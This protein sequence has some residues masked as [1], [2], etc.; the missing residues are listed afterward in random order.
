MAKDHLV[1]ASI[2]FL[3]GNSSFLP[4]MGSYL[5]RDTRGVTQTYRKTAQAQSR[6]W[7]VP[8]SCREPCR[9]HP[10]YELARHFWDPST[11]ALAICAHHQR[12]FKQKSG[13]GF[14]ELYV[15]TSFAVQWLLFAVAW[16]RCPG[17][18]F[19]ESRGHKKEPSVEIPGSWFYWLGFMFC[20]I[21]IWKCWLHRG[22]QSSCKKKVLVPQ[23]EK[24]KEGLFV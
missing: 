24:S 4:E 5:G 14:S 11:T 10:K 13:H 16:L 1:S 17:V 19:D 3:S 7:M 15:H 9:S 12:A 20:I 21:K 18:C 23:G 8:G 2:S 22:Q 6:G